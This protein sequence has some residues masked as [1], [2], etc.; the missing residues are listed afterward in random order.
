M[1]PARKKKRSGSFGSAEEHAELSQE[2]CTDVSVVSFLHCGLSTKY[3]A[4]PISTDKDLVVL[5]FHMALVALLAI[6]MRL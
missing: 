6:N 4:V 3:V 2:I 1:L 5:P